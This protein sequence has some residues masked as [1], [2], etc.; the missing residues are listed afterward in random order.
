MCFRADGLR[1]ADGP[2]LPGHDVLQRAQPLAVRVPGLVPGGARVPSRG[3]LLRRQPPG[4]HAGHPLP[5]AERDRRDQPVLHAA[6]R[7]QHVLHDQA[8]DQ[9]RCVSSTYVRR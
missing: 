5:A 7:R 1:E 3:L 6:A 2:R 4:A 8:A 9:I